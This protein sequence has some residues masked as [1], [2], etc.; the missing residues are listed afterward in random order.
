MAGKALTGRSK[1]TLV[2]VF[3]LVGFEI[4]AAAIA[5]GWAIAGLFELGPVIGYGLMAIFS[6][7]G[8][9]LLWRFMQNA[10]K[11]EPDHD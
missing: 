4:F 7:F 2:S 5:G 6:A 8:A 3:I 11:Y 10:V 9:Y 1:I